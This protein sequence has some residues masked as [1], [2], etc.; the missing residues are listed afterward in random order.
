MGYT[1]EL[2]A[3]AFASMGGDPTNAVAA[4]K[5]YSSVNTWIFS[6]AAQAG[7]VGAVAMAVPGAHIPAMAVDLAVL[8]H[9]MAYCC[10]G[11]GEIRNCIVLGKPDFY[12]ILALWSEAVTI[13]EI[14]NQ[15]VTHK[16][17]EDAL[18]KEAIIVGS[19]PMAAIIST[20]TQQQIVMIASKLSEKSAILLCEHAAAILGEE[21]GKAV[22]TGAG[23]ALKKAGLKVSSK[24]LLKGGASIGNQIGSQIGSQVGTKVGSKI[25]AKVA[26][27][28]SSKSAA[29]LIAGAIPIIGSLT[30]ASINA[31]FV[32]NIAD[33]AD[34]YYSSA[35]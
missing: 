24:L 30:G 18:L 12:N 20:L 19:V 6:Q 7:A 15:V 17:L 33:S 35:K 5:G 25:A 34:L 10:W 22:A 32:K 29:K 2:F 4:A 31:Y 23:L 26:A 13:N 27:K 3:D 8:L 9:K 1:A 21:V 14:K 16:A 11:I 28:L